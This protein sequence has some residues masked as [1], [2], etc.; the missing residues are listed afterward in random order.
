MEHWTL[1]GER[2]RLIHGPAE[3]DLIPGLGTVRFVV[4]C[5]G[6]ATRVLTLAKSV[7]HQI[8]CVD[9][10][11]WKSCDWRTL[12]PLDFVRTCA[13]EMAPED[14][15]K[16]LIRWQSLSERQQRQEEASRSW[17]LNNWL[18]W[19]EPQDRCWCWWDANEIDANHLVVAVAVKDWPFPW[20]ALAW[21]FRGSGANLVVPEPEYADA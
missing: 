21:L 2:D 14:A 8:N 5:S 12:L 13:A 1:A 15:Q 7:L 11:D 6:K 3:G 18:Y 4:H 16:W 17:S 19:L 10:C 20:G 9:K